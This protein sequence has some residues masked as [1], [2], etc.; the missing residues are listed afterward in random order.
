MHFSQTPAPIKPR[1]IDESLSANTPLLQAQILPEERREHAKPGEGHHSDPDGPQS[2]PVR[3][4][5]RLLKTLSTT[6]GSLQRSQRADEVD[7]VPRVAQPLTKRLQ[8]PTR[9]LPDA[10][11]KY[12]IENGR[13]DRQPHQAAGQAH[14]DDQPEARPVSSTCGTLACIGTGSAKPAPPPIPSTTCDRVGAGQNAIGQHGLGQARARLEHRKQDQEAGPTQQWHQRLPRSPAVHQI[15]PG[16][17][18]RDAGCAECKQRHAGPVEAT[19]TRSQGHPQRAQAEIQDCQQEGGSDY[20]QVYSANTTAA[21][22]LGEQGT[23]QRPGDAT[24]RDGNGLQTQSEGTLAKARPCSSRPTPRDVHVVGGGEQ[25]AAGREEQDG[26][27]SGSLR[28][29]TSATFEYIGRV[30]TT[31]R[32]KETLAQKDW[33]VFPCSSLA[34][35]CGNVQSPFSLVLTLSIE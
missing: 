9:D 5:V 11:A 19:Q 34:M 27:W 4:L 20:W 30:T 28:P 33:N 1:I 22:M 2:L 24:G 25:G 35:T 14:R 29:S 12:P 23:Q 31:P 15:S 6:F 26:K 13:G 18:E 16:Q 7:G 8:Q 3:L 17:R 32:R 21:D 10:P